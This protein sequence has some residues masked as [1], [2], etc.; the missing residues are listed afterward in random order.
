MAAG[1]CGLRVGS[2]CLFSP[3]CSPTSYISGCRAVPGRI[4][5]NRADLPPSKP[6][7]AAIL[8]PLAVI[9]SLL[10]RFFCCGPFALGR[11]GKM[12]C[13]AR[14]QAS[15]LALLRLAQAYSGQEMHLAY[16]YRFQPRNP[17]QSAWSQNVR[18]RPKALASAPKGTYR[19]LKLGQ[20]PH[21]GRLSRYLYTTI[22]SAILGHSKG[23]KEIVL[24]TQC[25]V[26]LL[27][28][29]STYARA[30]YR[31]GTDLSLA[32]DSYR[33]ER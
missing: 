10:E 19:V 21:P 12:N 31:F 11:R 27:E 3:L 14:E 17:K 25:T 6:I 28:G 4:R 8:F 30:V 18:Y 22:W 20:W 16:P 9:P 5:K 13:L 32:I 33:R 1:K 7:W 24:E 26:A 29:A 23:Q 2:F 15:L